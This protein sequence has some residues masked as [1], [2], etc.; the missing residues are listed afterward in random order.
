MTEQVH[1]LLGLIATLIIGVIAL[2]F[3]FIYH[4]LPAIVLM[5]FFGGFIAGVFYPLTDG[6]ILFRYSWLFWTMML[7]IGI[8]FNAKKAEDNMRKADASLDDDGNEIK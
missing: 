6:F 8:H 3:G 7:F 2:I 1:K 5:F 4:I